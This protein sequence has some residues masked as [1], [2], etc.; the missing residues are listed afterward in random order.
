VKGGPNIL[1]ELLEASCTTTFLEANQ[2]RWNY[3][4]VLPGYLLCVDEMDM[5]ENWAAGAPRVLFA[6]LSAAS[7]SAVASVVVAVEEYSKTYVA[8]KEEF[9][10]TGRIKGYKFLA[11]NGRD[12]VW[13]SHYDFEL[14]KKN[15]S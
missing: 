11:P 5:T 8:A 12:L 7:E 14:L 6:A 10:K 2:E 13:L 1:G 9:E 4:D 15:K 3:V